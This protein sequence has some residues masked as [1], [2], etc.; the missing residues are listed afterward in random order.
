MPRVMEP[1]SPA[2]T[3]EERAEIQVLLINQKGDVA[4]ERLLKHV[5]YKPGWRLSVMHNLFVESQPFGGVPMSVNVR[6]DIQ[7]ENSARP[8]S[9]IQLTSIRPVDVCV[10][11]IEELQAGLFDAVIRMERHEASEFFR[12]DGV[13]PFW[14]H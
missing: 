7:T 3:D 11:T 4:L 6:I 9:M 12:V 1:E 5:T 10:Y 14:P 8:G 2:M 13:A